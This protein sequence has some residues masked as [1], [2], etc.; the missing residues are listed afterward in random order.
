[1]SDQ[2]L[3]RRTWLRFSLRTLLL[4]TTLLCVWLGYETSQVRSRKALR[5]ELTAKKT[6]NFVTAD[7]YAQRYALIGRKPDKV[8][9]IS[10][11]RKLL[12]DEPIQEIWVTSWWQGFSEDDRRRA[13]EAFP[14]AEQHESLPEP[15]HPGCF[16]AGTLVETTSGPRS[17][18]TI[19][20]GDELRIAERDGSLGSA[21]VSSIFVTTNWLFEIETERGTLV[22]T[23]IQPL[24]TS[25]GKIKPAGKLQPGDALV[26]CLGGTIE[27]TRVV[28]VEATGRFEKVF[29]LVLSDSE[30][31]IANGYLARSKPPVLVHETPADLLSREHV[32]Q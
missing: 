17:I 3:P 21:E 13:L 30:V 1:M 19:A 15:C 24:C 10:P 23:E 11:L 32:H 18:E 8:A 20:V 27:S 7:E 28:R 12:G 16:P 5:A 26:C 9:R 4:I 2:P 22:T 14:E 31:F 29:N 6:F 25:L